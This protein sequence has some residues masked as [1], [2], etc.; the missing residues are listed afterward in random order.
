MKVMR[1]L[2]LVLMAT[3]IFIPLTAN[4]EE[5]ESGDKNAAQV[6]LSEVSVGGIVLDSKKYDYEQYEVTTYIDGD[7]NPFTVEEIDKAMNSFA[8][9]IFG[10]TKIIASLIDTGLGMLYEA[11]F[12]DKWAD[13]IANVSDIIYDNLYASFGVIL[14]V[15]AVLQIFMYYVSERNGIKAWRTTGVLIAVIVLAGVWF[16]NAGYFLKSM[17]S[18][19]NDVQAQVMKAGIVLTDEEVKKGEELWG[20][21]AIMRN[22]YHDLIVYRPYLIMNYGTTVE[23]DIIEKDKNRITNL[24]STTTDKEGYKKREEIATNEVEKL[25]NKYMSPSYIDMKIGIAFVSLIFSVLLGVPMLLIAFVN[26]G[27]QILALIVAMVLPVAFIMSILPRFSNSG[28][29]TFE[30]L[31]GLFFMKAFVGLLIMF[32]FAIITM[33]DEAF[34]MVNT[35]MYML[36]VVS[37]S[38]AIILMIKYRDKIIEFVTA[39]HVTTVDGGIATKAYEKTIRQPAEWMTDGVRKGVNMA[40]RKWKGNHQGEEDERYQVEASEHRVPGHERVDEKQ[41]SAKRTKGVHEVPDK[42]SENQDL[43]H[44]AQDPNIVDLSKYRETRQNRTQQVATGKGENERQS[45]EKDAE[46]QGRHLEE[47]HKKSHIQEPTAHKQQQAQKAFERKNRRPQQP[48]EQR[49]QER[50][51]QTTVKELTQQTN[52]RDVRTPQPPV[53]QNVVKIDPNKPITK[54]EAQKQIEARNT[55]NQDLTNPNRTPQNPKPEKPPKQRLIQRLTA[56]RKQT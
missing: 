24:L 3:V 21:I 12:I 23:K 43:Q 45:H 5:K 46:G 26:A 14:F 54:W 6:E 42:K 49:P 41:R 39:G 19:S 16:S 30:R 27:I 11:N 28:W 17:N 56:K 18:I 48:Q 25:N 38:I 35:P 44:S 2:L 40:R 1:K 47:Q 52:A 53:N 51:V 10:L 22:Q 9:M 34:P 50:N 20:S 32:M 31:V 29:Y 13:T 7:W 55:T 4:A 37:V 15:V 33:V 8:N 36:N